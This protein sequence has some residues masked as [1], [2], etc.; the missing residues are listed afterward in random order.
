MKKSIPWKDWSQY[1]FFQWFLVLLLF[2][3]FFFIFFEIP[4]SWKSE[5]IIFGIFFSVFSLPLFY[6]ASFRWVIPLHRLTVHALQL[7]HR[8]YRSGQAVDMEDLDLENEHFL[9]LHRALKDISI[10]LA[11]R[12]NQLAFQRQENEAMLLAL[13]DPLVSVDRHQKIQFC[14]TQFVQTFQLKNEQLISL[15]TSLR[16]P[17]V[18]ELVQQAMQTGQD[19]RQPLSFFAAGW[20]TARD[21]VVSIS[22]VR[23]ADSSST[24]QGAVVVFHDMTEI[25]QAEKIRR[26]FFEN[27]SHELRT[28]LTSMK[29]FTDALS[30]DFQKQDYSH[31]STFLGMIQKSI[32]RVIQLVDDML[33]LTQFDQGLLSIHKQALDPM[34]ATQ[35]VLDHLS[36]KMKEKNIFVHIQSEADQVW[37]DAHHL[38]QVLNNLLEN[39]IKYGTP[40]GRVD[41]LWKQTPQGVE[42]SIKDDGPGISKEHLPRIFERFYRV[43][44]GRSRD[45]GGTGLGLAIVKHAML[46]QSGSVKVE[47]VLGQGT[48]FICSFPNPDAK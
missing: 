21:F 10:K 1:V 5:K 32:H 3:S 20:E 48:E 38:D 13:Q 17:E 8:K 45:Q 9:T 43:D 16:Y 14:N 19:L 2:W 34:A 26:Q 29:G 24:V 37:A 47:S 46:A 35:Q 18:S 31:A 12:K 4:I 25:H 6:L 15:T 40:G 42:L 30:E 23:S 41:V 11:R 36:W 22:C 28:P 44:R 7:S 39:A 27:A 33:A